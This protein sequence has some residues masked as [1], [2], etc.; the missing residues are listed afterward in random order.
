MVSFEDLER[1]AVRVAIVILI[2]VEIYLIGTQYNASFDVFVTIFVIVLAI[3]AT[4]FAFNLLKYKQRD[5]DPH[6]AVIRNAVAP[7]ASEETR[8]EVAKLLKSEKYQ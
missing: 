8:E 2:L 6:D 3:P 4:Y 7:D 5:V 1:P